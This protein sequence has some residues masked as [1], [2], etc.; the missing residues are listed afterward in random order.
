MG[1]GQAVK[2]LASNLSLWVTGVLL[3][4]DAGITA[5]SGI[6]FSGLYRSSSLVGEN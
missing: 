1:C 6:E 3:P 5:V 2:F 4:V